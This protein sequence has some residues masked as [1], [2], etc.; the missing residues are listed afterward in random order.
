MTGVVVVW[1]GC[2][3]HVPCWHQQA[4]QHSTGRGRMWCSHTH[5][6][7]PSSPQPPA[8]TSNHQPA[9]VG[10]RPVV[11][12]CETRIPFSLST[13]TTNAPG[14]EA[15]EKWKRGR[16]SKWD[17]R[18]SHQQR[19]GV[20][21]QPHGITA[22]LL[23]LHMQS[24]TARRGR[25]GVSAGIRCVQITVCMVCSHHPNHTPA[26]SQLHA[27]GTRIGREGEEKEGEE[28]V[29]AHSFPPLHIQLAYTPSSSP[30]LPSL[31]P[32]HLSSTPTTHTHTI[33]STDLSDN[34][35]HITAPLTQPAS[36]H[37]HAHT[38]VPSLTQCMC[39]CTEETQQQQQAP[40]LAFLTTSSS[41]PPPPACYKC[42]HKQQVVHV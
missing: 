39:Q 3:Q 23:C 28:R 36:P 34:H 40:L 32:S 10:K 41:C 17:G 8:Q 31:P 30:L 4:T 6:D 21:S 19:K 15:T 16:R 27:D 11:W 37:T 14:N 1:A 25:E 13:H 24:E 22:A 26:L 7:T 42:T 33:T 18:G 29:A 12:L 20:Q 38:H 5:S 35:L 2:E 9:V